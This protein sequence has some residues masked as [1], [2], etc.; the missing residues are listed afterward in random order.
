MEPASRPAIVECHR[1]EII[2]WLFVLENE[3]RATH[4]AELTDQR[5]LSLLKD[6]KTRRWYVFLHPLDE[7]DGIEI[8]WG[9]EFWQYPYTAKADRGYARLLQ[10]ARQA[11]EIVTEELAEGLERR[12]RGRADWSGD[13]AGGSATGSARDPA[14]KRPS[15]K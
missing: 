12:R 2:N 8:P 4:R 13:A 15:R 14:E 6:P 9:T 11:G 5:F 10:E 7:T 1:E 3:G